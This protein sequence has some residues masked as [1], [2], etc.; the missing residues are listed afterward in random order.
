MIQCG[1]S[2]RLSLAATPSL[3]AH[4]RRALASRLAISPGKTRVWGF[5]RCP[6]GRP[7]VRRGQTPG[8]T[9]GSRV[10]GYKNASGRSNWP[11]RDPI[12]EPGFELLRHGKAATI[13]ANLHA[14]VHNVPISQV[15]PF[16][17]EPTINMDDTCLNHYTEINDAFNRALNRI[18]KADE[19]G[20]VPSNLVPYVDS[21][22]ASRRN[23]NVVCGGLRHNCVCWI[24]R[25]LGWNWAPG[26][27]HLCSRAF[28]AR[29]THRLGSTIL[30]EIT[31]NLCG[32]TILHEAEF[33]NWV[34]GL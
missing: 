7:Q 13:A 24:T 25:A 28:D 34:D 20:K 4:D 27:I 19:G 23:V 11:S 2:S 21:L 17:L 9:P 5:H 26:T 12:E 14:F 1:A 31:K 16:G 30:V 15:D 29:A 10:C 22:K 18:M 6:S 8:I 3:A 33:V 32:L